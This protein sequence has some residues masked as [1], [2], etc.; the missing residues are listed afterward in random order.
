[1]KFP[2]SKK[3]WRLSIAALALIGS[4]LFIYFFWFAGS[5]IPTEIKEKENSQGT[6]E[7]PVSS[8]YRYDFQKNL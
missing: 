1:M 4:G 6:A 7:K 5:Q 3:F 2:V 8:V